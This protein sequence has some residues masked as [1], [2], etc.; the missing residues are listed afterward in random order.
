MS[1]SEVVPRAKLFS[2]CLKPP[3]TTSGRVWLIGLPHASWTGARGRRPRGGGPGPRSARRGA[4]GTC[5]RPAGGKPAHRPFDP[6]EGVV[7]IGLGVHRAE[8]VVPR[9]V[10]VDAL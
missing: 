1:S 5:G 8:P 7:E 4:R 9:G 2:S 3:T 10:E 6:L